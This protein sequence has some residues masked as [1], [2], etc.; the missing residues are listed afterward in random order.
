[1]IKRIIPIAAVVVAIAAILGYWVA[2]KP[3]FIEQPDNNNTLIY[4]ADS[5]T[6]IDSVEQMLT[7]GG[8]VKSKL[9]FSILSALYRPS[10]KPKAGAYRI[11]KNMS[12]IAF[13]NNIYKGRQ[14]PIKLKINNI[15]LKT[16]LAS[17]VSRQTSIDSTAFVA[18][19]YDSTFLKNYNLN[20]DNCLTLFIPN[21]YEVY[22]TIS[23]KELFDRMN[24]EY[25]RFWTDDRKAKA[26]KIPLTPVEVAI[27]ASIVEEET[28]KSHEKPIIAGLYINRLNTGMKLQADPTARYALDDFSITQVLYSH[29]RINSRY[30]TYTNFGLPPGPIRVPSIEG[31]DAVLNHTKHNYIFMCAKPELNGEHNFATTYAEHERNATAYHRAYKEWKNRKSE[32]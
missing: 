9:S 5:Q 18:L 8:Y 30:N 29:T 4:I 1:M 25:D 11:D 7:E 21:T 20:P 17:R 23:P 6:D 32:K 22:W 27:L 12:N 31:I 3:N 24:K 19:L 10:E 16:Q 2:I 13:L 26:A 15:R 14:T 28:N